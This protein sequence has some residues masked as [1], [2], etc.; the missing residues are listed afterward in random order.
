L[1]GCG[2]NPSPARCER[3]E[4]ERLRALRENRKRAPTDVVRSRARLRAALGAFSSDLSSCGHLALSHRGDSIDQAADR[5]AEFASPCRATR[6]RRAHRSSVNEP[7]VRRP[8]VLVVD[9]RPENLYAFRE[10]LADVGCDIHCASSGAEGIAQSSAREHA[11]ILVDLM[12]PDIDGLEVA[13]SIRASDSGRGTPVVLVTAAD[14]DDRTTAR[15]YAAGVADFVRKPI[16]PTILAAKV[17]IFSELWSARH[18]VRDQIANAADRARLYAILDNIPA[19]LAVY[20]GP[21]LRIAFANPAFT[22]LYRGREIVGLPAH[23]AFA[24][25]IGPRG[26]A[27]LNDARTATSASVFREYEAAVQI[28]GRQERRFYDWTLRPLREAPFGDALMSIAID[29]TES[30]RA[31]Q[32]SEDSR[33]RAIESEARQRL[34]VERV[35]RLQS[36]VG[37]LAGAARTTDVVDAMVGNAFA[38]LGAD[39]CTLYA[40]EGTDRLVL[41]GQRGVAPELLG[42][43]SVLDRTAASFSRL[44]ETMF[45]ETAAEYAKRF[46]EVAGHAASGPRVQAFW[47]VPLSARGAFIGVLAM[48][49]HREHVFDDEARAYILAFAQQCAFA[50]DRAHLFDE[51]IARNDRLRIAAA[52]SRTLSTSLDYETTLANVARSLVPDVADFCTVDLLRDDGLLEQVA[53]AHEDR[54]KIDQARAFRRAFPPDPKQRRGI[55]GVLASGRSELYAHVTQEMISASSRNDEH[56]AALRDA[57]LSSIMLVPLKSS[58]KTFGVLTL[59]ST[60]PS[61]RYGPADLGLLEDLASRASLAVDNARLHDRAQRAV[62]LRDEFLAI[63]SHELRTPIATLDLRARILGRRM[64][65][66]EPATEHLD[67]IKA[68]I[69]RLE[70]LVGRMLDVSRLDAGHALDLDRR[71]VDLADV[72]RQVLD[73]WSE[74]LDRTAMR[75]QLQL[76]EARGAWDPDRLRQLVSNLVANAIKYAPGS[77]LS[78]T[79]EPMGDRARL[80]VADSGPGIPAHSRSRVFER[81]ERASTMSGGFGVGLWLCRRIAEEHGGTLRLEEQASSGATF[82]VELPVVSG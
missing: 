19:A 65:N 24:G 32:A 54:E 44:G 76:A 43:I 13:A 38:A 35:T 31:R 62:K 6:L 58:E 42:P 60:S 34:L 17:R 28:S 21:E 14:V 27:A 69:K 73:D 3:H 68:Q 71:T 30:V 2:A 75:L 57:G 20:E 49:Y 51:E 12:M 46:P 59:V 67:K 74:Q 52:V 22:A 82:V 78:L 10:A 53:V 7:T 72:V 63:A 8:S 80:V 39:T 55:Y 15:A 64:E 66:G 50:L 23:E 79:I 70:R 56:H 48:G 61:R 81:F 40:A 9:D 36:A 11:L 37:A 26:L 45:V 47:S 5:N 41:V 29:V 18:A 25:L 77:E 4:I 16:D 1:D 33:K